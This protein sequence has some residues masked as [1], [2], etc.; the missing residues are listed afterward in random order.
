MGPELPLEHQ[1]LA[2]LGELPLLHLVELLL[3]LGDLALGLREAS[4]LCHQL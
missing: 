3:Q 4:L 1:C 2:R